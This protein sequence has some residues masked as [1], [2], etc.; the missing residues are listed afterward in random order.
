MT[1]ELAKQPEQKLL[2]IGDYLARDTVRMSLGNSLGGAIDVDHFI[3]QMNVAFNK[4]PEVAACTL[5]SKFEAANICATLGLLPTLGQV[6]LIPRKSLCT[7]MP[8]WQ[9]YQAL[10]L[11]C[12]DVK[13]VKAVLIHTLDRYEFDAESEQLSHSYD[14]FAEGRTFTDFADL[15]GGYLVITYTDGR[16][17]Q[18]HCVSVETMRKARR[19][20]QSDNIWKAWF[21]EQC[22]KTVYRNAFARRV[23]PM[24]HIA[25]MR[26]ERLVE[27]T[28]AAEGNEPARVEAVAVEPQQKPSRVTQV[29]RSITHD[30]GPELYDET[31]TV[32]VESQ[33][34]PT[35][36]KPVES[37][38]DKIA[39]VRKAM[40]QAVP[41][42][43]TRCAIY[44]ENGIS[45]PDQDGEFDLFSIGSLWKSIE[46]LNEG[47]RE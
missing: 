14:P 6:A 13:T 9:G 47:S 45:K 4:S 20:A 28:D 23:I 26:V 40:L 39:S 11:R 32:A 33:Q 8:Q 35:K 37:L 16:P 10:M 2:K 41:D 44:A 30:Q 36:S 19:C 5:T 46:S 34:K 43:G 27:A 31:N 42:E 3:A 24:D 17:K 1:T 15:Q 21:Q 29:R 12:P 18:F 22:L 25:A 38:T 7:V